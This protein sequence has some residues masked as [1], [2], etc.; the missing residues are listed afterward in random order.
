M[1]VLVGSENPVKITAVEG[2]FT[3]YFGEVKVLGVKVDSKVSSQP[4]NEEIFAGARNRAQALRI[5]NQKKQLGADFFVGI[6]GGIIKLTGRWFAFGGICVLDKEGQ[7]GCGTSPF[8]ELPPTITKDLLKGTELGDV[9]DKLTGDTNTKQKQGAVG[10]FTKGILQRKDFYL[11]GLL[12]ALI[13]FL[14]Q[15]SYFNRSQHL[16]TK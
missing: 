1:K 8:F 11:N 6:E 2:A 9:M 5:I 3:R 14:H 15:E 4:I 13:P 10:Y 7:E 12:M 16:L